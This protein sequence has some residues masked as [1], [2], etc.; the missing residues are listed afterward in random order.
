MR[1]RSCPN[2]DMVLANF[3]ETIITRCEKAIIDNY[4][5]SDM[6]NRINRLSATYAHNKGNDVVVVDYVARAMLLP[7]DAPDFRTYEGPERRKNGVHI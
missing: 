7:E 4:L 6:R 2:R 3:G 5:P 1:L